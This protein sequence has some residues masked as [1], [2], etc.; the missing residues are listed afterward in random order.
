[1]EISN[2]HF[3]QER[4]QRLNYWVDYDQIIKQTPKTNNETIH[5]RAVQNLKEETVTITQAPNKFLPRVLMIFCWILTSIVVISN[6]FLHEAIVP[7]LSILC[8]W[9]SFSITRSIDNNQ[10]IAEL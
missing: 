9:I 2:Q 7:L 1:M 10:R 5:S 4:R 3:Y 8:L 6:V